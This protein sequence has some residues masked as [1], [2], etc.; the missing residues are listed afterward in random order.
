MAIYQYDGSQKNPPNYVGYRVAVSINGKLHQKWF[1]GVKTKTKEMESLEREWKFKQQLHK[2]SRM[3]ERK[4]LVKNS[5][6]VTGVAGIKMK[7]V[8]SSKRKKKKVYRS[9]APS[10]IVSGSVDGDKFSK[11]YNIKTLGFDMAWFKACQFAAEK[12]GSTLLDKMLAKKPNV[13]QFQII[14]RW[15]TKRGLDIPLNRMPN[16]LL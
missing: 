12:Y 4:E 5:A 11:K 3:R 9:Y 10:F 14:Y 8:V 2:T 15:Q 6:Y 1:K 16:E 13:E 7:F